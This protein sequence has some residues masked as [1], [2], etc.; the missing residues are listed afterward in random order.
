MKIHCTFHLQYPFF[1]VLFKISVSVSA[2]FICT[3]LKTYPHP[4]FQ[5]NTSCAYF[6][7]FMVQ[8]Q[9]Q[10]WKTICLLSFNT[11]KTCQ[12]IKTVRQLN[13]FQCLPLQSP[14]KSVSLQFLHFNNSFLFKSMQTTKQYYPHVKP[15]LSTSS[16]YKPDM[17]WAVT[18]FYFTFH[19]SEHQM[20][21][22]DI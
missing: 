12:A 13:I 2:C 17:F 8:R 18:N 4:K 3:H 5:H 20:F 15:H 16:L 22:I 6:C 21:R 11:S 9:L 10:T 1:V 7:L 19:S 14:E